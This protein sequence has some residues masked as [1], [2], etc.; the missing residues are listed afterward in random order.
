MSV[1]DFRLKSKGKDRGPTQF[2]LEGFLGSSRI[3]ESLLESLE[4]IEF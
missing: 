2:F 1:A 3:H 4:L